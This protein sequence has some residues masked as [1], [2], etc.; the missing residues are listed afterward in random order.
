MNHR[1]QPLRRRGLG[2][3]LATAVGAPVIALGMLVGAGPT[4]AAA[5]TVISC[6]LAIQNPHNSTH[7]IGT[8]NV[9]A[10]W[11]CTEPVSSLA[12]TV[13]LF[14]DGVLVAQMSFSNAGQAF[15]QGNAA[16][17]CVPGAYFGQATGTVVFPPGYDPPEGSGT[18][19]SPTILITCT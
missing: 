6:T 11:T 17:T 10:T 9:V 4:N 18:V 14:L 13:S 3:R 1:A 12:M 8:V 19:Q 16:Q 7:V 15:L 5:Q 2:I